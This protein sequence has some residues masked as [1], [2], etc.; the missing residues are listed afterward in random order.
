MG[1]VVS[2]LALS[3]DCRRSPVVRQIEMTADC[4]K[5]SAFGLK[6]STDRF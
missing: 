5:R 6:A 4:G 1:V 3:S 2:S